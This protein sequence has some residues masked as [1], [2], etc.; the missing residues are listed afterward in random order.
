MSCCGIDN[1]FAFNIADIAIFAGA[2]GLALFAGG[3]AKGRD[4]GRGLR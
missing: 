1:P 2:I 4:G 3:G